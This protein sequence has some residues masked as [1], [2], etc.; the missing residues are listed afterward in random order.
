MTYPYPTDPPPPPTGVPNQGMPQGMPAG[1][2][3]YPP[4]PAPIPPGAQ[5]PS[6]WAQATP[7]L[8]YSL[9]D[10]VEK[11]VSPLPLLSMIAGIVALPFLCSAPVT[12]GWPV[13]SACVGVAAVVLGHVGLAQPQRAGTSRNN[14]MAITGLVL[15]YVML[16]ITVVWILLRV[17]YGPN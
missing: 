13:L 2:V 15:G 9:T 11:G 4:Y 3:P 12:D 5:V 14:G 1:T 17:R 8:S 6:P 7:V 16:S 10:R